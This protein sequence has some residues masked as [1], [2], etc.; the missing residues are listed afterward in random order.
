[1]IDPDLIF[2]RTGNRMFQMAFV[3]AWCKK[4]RPLFNGMPDFYL[5]DPKYFEGYEQEIKQL[6][7][8]NIPKK[9]D[10]VAIHV[11]KGDYM[12]NPFY[13]DLMET[14]YYRDAMALF[15][16]ESFV[17]YSDDIEW[18]KQQKIFQGCEFSD[19][20]Y[21]D[22]MNEMASCKAIIIANSTFSWWAAYISPYASKI[23]APK[24]WYSDKIERTIC[25]DNWIRR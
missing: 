11:R 21:L 9:T 4:N 22:A 17:V 8:S 13:V 14:P 1:M 5:Q 23:V 25:P 12:G 20:L 2:G 15:P 7:G 16:G 18:C 24:A 6:Y 10:M 19:K 3:Y